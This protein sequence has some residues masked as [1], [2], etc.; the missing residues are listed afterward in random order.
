MFPSLSVHLK[1]MISEYPA[2]TFWL[3]LYWFGAEAVNEAWAGVLQKLHDEVGQFVES[4]SRST[5]FNM[6]PTVNWAS[7]LTHGMVLLT[8]AGFTVSN[9]AV[10]LPPPGL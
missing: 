3:T 10:Q 5:S 9:G 2:M 8:K 1:Q 6:F 7:V 4:V